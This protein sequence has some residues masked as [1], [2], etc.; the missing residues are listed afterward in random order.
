MRS[1][2]EVI[3]HLTALHEAYARRADA[4]GPG[5]PDNGYLRTQAKEFR[6]AADSLQ[7]TIDNHHEHVRAES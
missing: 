4:N 5:H 7:A 6:R 2:P 3:Q 1:L